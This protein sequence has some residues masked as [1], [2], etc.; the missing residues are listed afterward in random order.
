MCQA[1]RKERFLGEK[2]MPQQNRLKYV[3]YLTNF[4][5]YQK[6]F[7]HIWLN[8]YVNGKSIIIFSQFYSFHII[9]Q[10][11]PSSFM[12]GFSVCLSV[13]LSVTFFKC[14]SHRIVMKV[15]KVITINK[16]DVHAKCQGQMSKVRIT[17][18]KTS[19]ASVWAFPVGGFSMVVTIFNHVCGSFNLFM[20]T[21][22]DV[23]IIPAFRIWG[24]VLHLEHISCVSTNW[25]QN[26][27]AIPS[28][29][30]VA[31]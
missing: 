3:V 20:A 29:F 11:R 16:S 6:Q 1:R 17:E 23:L 18:I 2:K 15:S 24:C 10:L 28:L 25:S 4:W 14:W 12:N 8:R 22:E 31:L 30:S 21:T 7:K 26:K 9:F 27:W 13:H 19:F 5:I